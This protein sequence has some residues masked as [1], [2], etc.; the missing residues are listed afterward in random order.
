MDPALSDIMDRIRG[1]FIRSLNLNVR[2]EDLPYERK[3]D[4]VAGL[5]SIA[6]LEFITAVENEF[7]ITIEPELLQ[8]EFVRDL[9]RLAA[10]VESAERDRHH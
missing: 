1:V 2:A 3:L 5:D 8:M 7:G 6:V 10:Y 9:P 4:E